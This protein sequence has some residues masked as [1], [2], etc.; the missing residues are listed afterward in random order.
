MIFLGHFLGHKLTTINNKKREQDMSF[1]GMMSYCRQQ[2]PNYAEP[3]GVNHRTDC[4]EVTLTE[5]AEQ[6][7][8]EPR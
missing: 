1:L 4:R 5:Q 7:L 8:I 6:V 3:Q 2:I